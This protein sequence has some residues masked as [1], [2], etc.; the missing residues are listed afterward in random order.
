MEVHL[1]VIGLLD[2]GDGRR[3][4]TDQRNR[5]GIDSKV[6]VEGVVEKREEMGNLGIDL[7]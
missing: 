1:Q 4:R 3:D 7:E 5:L 2:G 6:V